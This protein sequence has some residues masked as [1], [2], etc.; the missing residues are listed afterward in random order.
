MIPDYVAEIDTHA[1]LNPVI[2]RQV[3][4]LLPHL[5]LHIDRAAHGIDHAVERQEQPVAGGFNDAAPVFLDLG[6]GQLMSDR[7]QALQCA[8][9]IG[10]HEP[11]ISRYISG[12]NR[13]K[14]TLHA[15]YCHNGAHYPKGLRPPNRKAV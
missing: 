10:T 9:L 6:I 15:F 7:F 4:I 11:T 2:R 8:F 13:N 3:P 12:E 1:E 14:P 5:V